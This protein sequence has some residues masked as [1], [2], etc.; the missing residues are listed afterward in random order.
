MLISAMGHS[1]DIDLD[2]ALNEVIK[3]CQQ[4]LDG[5]KP[6]AGILYV[7]GDLD[8]KRV[9]RTIQDAFPDCPISGCS[10]AG[11]SSSMA[12][13]SHDSIALW[14]CCSNKVRAGSG[15]G[16]NLSIDVK[17]AC[18]QAVTQARNELND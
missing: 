17:K 13:F 7:G 3:Q 10:T 5:H 4:G 12:G 9:A 16:H 6:T 14:L 8:M 15:V 18:Q 1:S 2:I 11:E